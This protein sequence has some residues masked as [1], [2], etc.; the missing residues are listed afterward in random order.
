[1]E[2][3]DAQRDGPADSK[4]LSEVLTKQGATELMLCKP[5][6]TNRGSRGRITVLVKTCQRRNDEDPAQEPDQREHD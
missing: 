5:C 1:M 6:H 4:Q 3:D 2:H